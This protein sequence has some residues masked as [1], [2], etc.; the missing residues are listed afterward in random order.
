MDLSRV[1]N[2]TYL[3]TQ[4]WFTSNK[5][6]QEKVGQL[7]RYNL[8]YKINVY[9]KDFLNHLNNL[10]KE[11]LFKKFKYAIKNFDYLKTKEWF[12]HNNNL[13][14]KLLQVINHNLQDNIDVT[15]KDFITHINEILQNYFYPKFE[16]IKNFDHLK[17]C[18]WFTNNTNLHIKLNRVIN[19]GLVYYIDGKDVDFIGNLDQIL[20]I[21]DFV[22]VSILEDQ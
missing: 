13:H 7:I 16:S 18:S 1:P 12:I 2:G 3:N 21:Y 10:I 4:P 6:I 5:V 22:I 15:R 11:N 19:L 17:N 14:Y 20:H 8:G 9:H